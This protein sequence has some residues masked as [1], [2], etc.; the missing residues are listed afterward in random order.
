MAHMYECDKLVKSVARFLAG[1]RPKNGRMY[2]FEKHRCRDSIYRFFMSVR[3]RVMSNQCPFCGKR[4]V[5]RSAMVTHI[6]SIHYHD[7]LSVA[8]IE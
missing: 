8:G 3:D 4:F 7:I 6:V 2:Y 5:R 1:F